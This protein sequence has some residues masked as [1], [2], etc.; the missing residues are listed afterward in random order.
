LDPGPEEKVAGNAMSEADLIPVMVAIQGET[1]A[2][3]G[4]GAEE[5]GTATIN[6]S[7][8][9]N[10]VLQSARNAG[11]RG[12]KIRDPVHLNWHGSCPLM[13]A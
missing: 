10:A 9:W 8:Y 13:A 5:P 7:A 1:P 4:L 11:I 2:L 3:L 6:P 12:P